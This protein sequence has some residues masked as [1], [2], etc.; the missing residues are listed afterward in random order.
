MKK[1]QGKSS[2]LPPCFLMI[3]AIV[4]IFMTVFSCDSKAHKHVR[5]EDICQCVYQEIILL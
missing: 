2:D 1:K 5:C 4:A 3:C